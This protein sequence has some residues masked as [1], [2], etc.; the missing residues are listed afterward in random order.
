MEADSVVHMHDQ[1]ACVLATL[2]QGDTNLLVDRGASGNGAGGVSQQVML[3]D[4]C[5]AHE[6]Y[7]WPRKPIVDGVV[8]R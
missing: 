1:T 4:R 5:E 7:P 3:E 8:L 6:P 2:R